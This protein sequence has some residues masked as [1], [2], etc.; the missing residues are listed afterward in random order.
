MLYSNLS[1]LPE[2]LALRH[3]LHRYPELSGQETETAHRIGTHLQKYKPDQLLTG[4]GGTGVAAIFHGENPGG[5]TILFRAELDA[6][7][8]AETNTDLAHLSEYEGKGH[9]CGHDGHMTIL[10]ALGSMLH[11]QRP[12]RGKVVLLYQPAEENGAGAWAVLQ[13][14]RFEK[15]IKPDYVFALHNLP[16]KP[17][18]QVVIRHNV[19]AA[20]STGMIVTY[21]GKPSHAA[22]PENGLNPGPAM[23]ETILAFE[24][25]I[26]NKK[27][28]QD[29]TLLTIIH[30]R[31][32]EIAFGTNPGFATVMATLRSYQPDDLQKLK[33]L[34][35]QQVLA[36]ATAHKL[37]HTIE[38]T[39]EFP[40]TQNHNTE[41]EIVRSAARELELAVEEAV[42]PF[43][44]SE[45]FGHFTARYKGALFGLGAG[46]AQPQL[47]HSDYDFPDEL[48]PTGAALFYGILQKI[49][50][51]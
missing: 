9:K 1:D 39:E 41:V 27:Q 7:P 38:F 20:A 3:T 50:R 10:T 48:I 23:A 6:L 15:E 18:H 8:I 29:L 47:H 43:R 13:D 4:L 19:F 37:E 26:Q 32:G 12:A 31:L 36:I 45:D 51:Q 5:P 25:I 28:F 2:L 42:Q 46:T 11:Q 33:E 40:A 30:A 49:L 44:W 24:E 14:K 34:A 21:Q 17:L 35:K 16:G 22:E